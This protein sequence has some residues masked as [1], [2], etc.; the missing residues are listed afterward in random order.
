MSSVSESSW[1]NLLRMAGSITTTSAGT[2]PLFNVSYSQKRR[3]KRKKDGEEKSQK[4][5]LQSED[6]KRFGSNI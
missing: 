5:P 6:E 2:S 4:V 1:F 3:K